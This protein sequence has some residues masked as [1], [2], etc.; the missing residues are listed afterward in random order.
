MLPP[1]NKPPRR[2]DRHCSLERYQPKMRIPSLATDE[3]GPVAPAGTGEASARRREGRRTTR[4]RNP[5]AR[6]QI[7]FRIRV[8]P[9]EAG[10]SIGSTGESA[11]PNGAK[12]GRREEDGDDPG[13]R[14]RVRLL[15]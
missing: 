12:H 2:S 14:D 7:P 3:A 5:V 13:G 11:G 1:G 9:F 15:G 10:G 6:T 8:W 4:G